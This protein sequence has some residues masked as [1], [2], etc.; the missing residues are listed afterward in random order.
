[1]D[2][3]QPMLG[4]M[5]WSGII[6]LALLAQR[7]PVV[8]KHWGHLQYALHSEELR[9]RLPIRMRYVTDN[10]N[11][12]F[13]QPTLFYATVVYINLMGHESTINV[14]LA[15]A[16]VFGRIVHSLIHISVNNVSWRA[17]SFALSSLCLLAMI[18]GEVLSWAA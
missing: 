18:F 2:I 8:I 15:W 4:M 3:L 9:P 5:I 13:E 1:M 16:Y 12:I 7:I 14:A 11:H 6:L 10:Y 17:T